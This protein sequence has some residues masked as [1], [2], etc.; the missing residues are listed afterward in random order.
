MATP[1]LHRPPSTE[2]DDP[3]SSLREDPD[4]HP[5]LPQLAVVLRD[6]LQLDPVNN[7]SHDG[8]SPPHNSSDT[9]SN[10]PPSFPPCS[11][12]HIGHLPSPFYK[13]VCSTWILCFV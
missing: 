5:S 3:S 2:G 1:V 6:A 4:E 13:F 8:G 11:A 12:L 10:Y 7:C 9:K